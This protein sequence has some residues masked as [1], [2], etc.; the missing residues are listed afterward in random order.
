MTGTGHFRSPVEDSAFDY[1]LGLPRWQL[2]L[3]ST[4]LDRSA[5][6]LNHI[7]RIWLLRRSGKNI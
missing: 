3:S 7:R 5:S 1:A 6:N 2:V 4:F